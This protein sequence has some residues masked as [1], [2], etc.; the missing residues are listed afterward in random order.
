MVVRF[1][2]VVHSKSKE[3]YV[4]GMAWERLHQAH[5][6]AQNRLQSLPLGQKCKTARAGQ[7]NERCVSIAYR[8]LYNWP[9]ST[10]DED[11]PFDSLAC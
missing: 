1:L 11:T 6:D 5:L 4:R 3:D 9:L 8:D 7:K 2:H 10:E